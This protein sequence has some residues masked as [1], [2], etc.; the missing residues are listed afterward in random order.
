ME[1]QIEIRDIEPIRVAYIPYKG[2]VTEANK[3]FP[4]VFK[5]IRSK[6]NG[7]PF[8]SYLSMNPETKTGVMELCVPTAQ[9]P[10]GKGIEV[11]EMTRI[12]AICVTH[13]GS[14]ETMYKAYATIDKFSAENGL[15]IT[16]PFREVFIKGPG[17]FLKGN[18]DKYITEI[19]FPIKEE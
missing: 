4:D 8:F 13:I 19:Q 9:T 2:I 10:V 5:A 3:V 17:M 18:P 6:T 11:K 14:Y 7:A 12:K 15:K 16:P 1:Y